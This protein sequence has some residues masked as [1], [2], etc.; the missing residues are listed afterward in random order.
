MASSED[1][2]LNLA[3]DRKIDKIVKQ[4]NYRIRTQILYFWTPIKT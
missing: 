2:L 1:V 3:N 4:W